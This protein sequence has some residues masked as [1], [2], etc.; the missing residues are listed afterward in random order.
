[1]LLAAP[2]LLMSA[3]VAAAAP[4]PLDEQARLAELA[5]LLGRAHAL[6]RL[7]AGS[8]DARW[9]RPMQRLLEVERPSPALRDRLV[10]R[11]NA[12]FSRAGADHRRC[13][14]AARAALAQTA[15]RGRDA[16]A[17]LAPAR[18]PAAGAALEA[19]PGPTP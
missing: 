12:G 4:R 9:R 11:F 5:E 17:A 18:D 7:C 8:E 14:A 16:A 6:H 1:M 13:D 15:A 3:A 2:A 19:T 10:K